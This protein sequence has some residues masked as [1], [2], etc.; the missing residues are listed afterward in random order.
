MAKPVEEPPLP[1]SLSQ[2]SREFNTV[3][4][5][6]RRRLGDVHEEPGPDCRYSTKQAQG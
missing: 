3:V 6:V 2:V 1:W 4:E 5:T